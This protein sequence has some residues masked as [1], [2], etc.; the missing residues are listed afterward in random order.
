[1]VSKYMGYN[2]LINR[3]YW[4]YNYPL[5]DHTPLRT[6]DLAAPKTGCQQD[7]CE[8]MVFHIGYGSKFEN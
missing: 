3:V 1:M 6:V 2:L 4:G 5:T 8:C 7:R